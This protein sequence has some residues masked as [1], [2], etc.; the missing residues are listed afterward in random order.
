ML[1]F[2]LSELT[3]SVR[4][5]GKAVVADLWN[6]NANMDDKESYENT[7]LDFALACDQ[8][9]FLQSYRLGTCTC[10]RPAGARPPS[11]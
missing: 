2:L 7:W 1:V 8:L 4:P 11:S 6:V 3:A 10:A 9:H 5:R